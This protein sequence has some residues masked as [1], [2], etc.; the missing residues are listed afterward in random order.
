[1]VEVNMNGEESSQRT[2]PS[3][4]RP[5]GWIKYS[6]EEIEDIIVKR[7]KEGL[8]SAMIGTVLRDTYGIPSVKLVLDK[9]IVDVLRD[10]GIAPRIPDDLQS[11]VRSAIK[12]HKHI[13]AHPKD[14]HSLRG[15]QLM[16]AK[17]H[18][19]S[20]YYRREGIIPPEWRY[21]RARAAS[22]LR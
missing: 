4:T 17:I 20:K 9:S 7:S 2:P 1:M 19:S 3:R 16:E 11:L 12:L 21:S 15:L 8:Q 10:H 18:R 22:L 5:Y 13:E 6:S 14:L